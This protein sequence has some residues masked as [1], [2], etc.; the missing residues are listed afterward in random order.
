M[1]PLNYG[2]AWDPA[3]VERLSSF[4]AS[5]RGLDRPSYLYHAKKAG[6][7]VNHSLSSYDH[8]C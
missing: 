6:G 5:E 7:D 2:Y 4:R 8:A 3:F 1:E